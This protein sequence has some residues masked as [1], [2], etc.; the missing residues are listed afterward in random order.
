[1]VAAGAVGE[2]LWPRGAL[3]EMTPAAGER[4][5]PEPASRP[6][7]GRRRRRTELLDQLE[8]V[9]GAFAKADERCAET[10]SQRSAS[11]LATRMRRCPYSRSGTEQ[12]IRRLG[13]FRPAEFARV[14]LDCV[15][16]SEPQRPAPERVSR[17]ESMAREIR[18]MIV[19]PTAE[20]CKPFELTGLDREFAFHPSLAS[21]LSG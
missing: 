6:R 17:A 9:L 8:R 15:L 3:D 10:V 2:A 16:V 11:W 20:V 7:S 18:S 14:A 21:A 19:A 13:R 12:M 5:A 1:M 4:F